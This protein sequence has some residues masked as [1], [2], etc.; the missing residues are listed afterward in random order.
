MTG[1]HPVKPGD[2]EIGWGAV[3]ILLAGFL[4]FVWGVNHSGDYTVAYN[5]PGRPGLLNQVEITCNGGRA[6]SSEGFG[7]DE[8]CSKGNGRAGLGSAAGVLALVAL[9]A[10]VGTVGYGYWI[11][12]SGGPKAISPPDTEGGGRRVRQGESD[13]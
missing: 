9:V 6:K 4:G 8:A 10:G 12:L 2:K 11:R 5:Y 1:P 3:L 7:A 13:R